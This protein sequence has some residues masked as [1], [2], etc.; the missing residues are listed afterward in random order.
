MA[1]LDDTALPEAP[2]GYRLPESVQGAAVSQLPRGW[3]WLYAYHPQRWQV[4]HGRIVPDLL[5]LSLEPGVGDTGP[6]Y[7]DPTTRLLAPAGDPRPAIM[8]ATRRGM[9]VLDPGDPRVGDYAIEHPCRDGRVWLDRH[10]RPIPG[11]AEVQIDTAASA[12]WRARVAAAMGWEPASHVLEAMLD[13]AERDHAAHVVHAGH[14]LHQREA[15][16]LAAEIETIRAALAPPAPPILTTPR[17]R[18]TRATAEE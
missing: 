4:Q 17:G 16:R 11:T 12:E 3:P 1:R 9:I 5:V 18:S 13:R 8:S 7:Q 2:R 15:A 14:P 6:Q 10:A